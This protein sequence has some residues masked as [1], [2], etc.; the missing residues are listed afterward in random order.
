MVAHLVLASTERSLQL[1]NP[2]VKNHL[3]Y[4]WFLR[5]LK[6]KQKKKKLAYLVLT[7]TNRN[8]KKEV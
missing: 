5:Q 3:I 6:Q 7:T 2:R 1:S 4:D 8:R